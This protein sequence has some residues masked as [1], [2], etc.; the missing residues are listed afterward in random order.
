MA[1]GHRILTAVAT[2]AVLAGLA[3]LILGIRGHPGPPQPPAGTAKLGLDGRHAASVAAAAP[4]SPSTPTRI[5]IPRIRVRSPLLGLGLDGHGRLRPPPLREVGKAGWYVHGVA[6]GARGPAIIAGHVDSARSGPGVFYELGKL[7]P[8]DRI[9]V[10]RRDRIEATFTVQAIRSVSKK[11]F[12]DRLVYGPVHYPALRLVTCGGSFDRA[13][14]HYTH[15]IVVFARLSSYHRLDGNT[16]SPP[17]RSGPGESRP[18]KRPRPH[19]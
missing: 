11:H 4:L 18:P 17:H 16:I 1:G 12:P 8:G 2:I 10:A 3:V 7:R 5:D 6:P 9:E 13:S 15:D 14:G 19:R